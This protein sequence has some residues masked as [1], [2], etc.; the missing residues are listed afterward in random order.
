MSIQ[1]K[2]KGN[3]YAIIKFTD[4]QAEFELFLFVKS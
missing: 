2:K 1:E 3:P 4:K